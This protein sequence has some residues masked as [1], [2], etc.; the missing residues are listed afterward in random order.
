M[1]GRVEPIP[2]WSGYLPAILLDAFNGR[3]SFGKKSN[4]NCQHVRPR[5]ELASRGT[6][7]VHQFARPS[8]QRH[9]GPRRGGAPLACAA[10]AEF[11]D[12]QEGRCPMRMLVATE[13]L[14]IPKKCASSPT[15]AIHLETRL[16]YCRVD[17]RRS[18]PRRPENRNWPGLFPAALTQSS[19]ACRVCSVNSN[20]TGCPVSFCRTIV[21][22]TAYPLGATSSPL[23]LT[24]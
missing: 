4:A 7:P 16:A 1:R 11:I 24:T 9:W 23:R 22:S 6:N 20:L 21:R 5:A 12:S 3:F 8:R 2:G 15:L 10:L 19:T 13:A 17:I 18:E 14:A